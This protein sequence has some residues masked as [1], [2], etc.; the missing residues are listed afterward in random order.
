MKSKIKKE[1]G[2]NSH[3][4]MDEYFNSLFRSR[5]G[6]QK[7]MMGFTM[8]EFALK[9]VAASIHAKHENISADS[10]EFKREMFLRIYGDDFTKEQQAEILKSIK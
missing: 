8:F 4:C 9:F 7:I 3:Y 10:K 5:S 6:Q 1:T 2:Y